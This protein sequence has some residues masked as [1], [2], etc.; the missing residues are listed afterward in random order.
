MLSTGAFNALLK[1]LEEPPEH[2]IFILA[3]TDLEKVPVT[4]ISRCQTLEFKKINNK[5]MFDRLK[6]ISK[7]ENIN[8]SDE[9]INEIVEESDGG[10]RDAIGL[11]DLAS[12][13]SDN[14][15]SVDDIMTINGNVSMNEIENITNDII[16]LE[17][18]KVIEKINDLNNGGKDLIKLTEKIIKYLNKFLVENTNTNICSIYEILLDSL[19]NMKKTNLETDYLMLGL[20]KIS[21][22]NKE[23]STPMVEEQNTIV[24]GKEPIVEV[25]K[26][27]PIIESKSSKK[28]SKKEKIVVDIKNVR[29]NNVF[30]QADK[31]ILKDIKSNWNKLDEYT[32]DRKV[33]AY[34]CELIDV[35]PVVAGKDY[36]A[37]SHKYDSFVDK[38]NSNIF[39]YEDTIKKIFKK[40]YKIVF[41]TDA[42]WK[43]FKEEY[44]NNSSK[45]IKYELKEETV[46][47][48]DNSTED[49]VDSDIIKKANE[50]FDNI[51]IEIEE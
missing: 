12:S 9:A 40:N 33:G 18:P 5:D 4:I 45:G 17:I 3:T 42:E 19:N 16:N 38:G 27:E 34:V 25:K 14:T 36:L 28:V 43:K 48:I 13:Y 2:V 24:E 39:D 30:A 50:L 32:L 20:Y 35:T 1:T 15:I 22:L 49:T 26:D 21:L 23:F 41:I 47:E 44:I 7:E 8:I 51:E 10:L 11:L 31:E 46:E 37:L 6:Q 29:M